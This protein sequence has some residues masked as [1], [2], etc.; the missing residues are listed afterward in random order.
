MIGL[1]Y[2]VQTKCTSWN[3]RR[4]TSIISK[5]YTVHYKKNGMCSL[6]DMKVIPA[7]MIQEK[8]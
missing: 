7:E 6:I 8:C 2:V 1:Y 5:R 4:F 3:N